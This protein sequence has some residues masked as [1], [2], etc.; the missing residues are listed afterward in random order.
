MP[1]LN[2]KSGRL[3]QSFNQ[4]VSM[5]QAMQQQAQKQSQTD[6][7]MQLQQ[8]QL[9]TFNRKE[10]ETS[11][12]DYVK[13]NSKNQ[14]W[15][16]FTSAM[17]TGSDKFNYNFI[18][19]TLASQGSIGPQDK[20]H[21]IEQEG[22]VKA[23]VIT[24]EGTS[25]KVVDIPM[26]A[27]LGK[28]YSKYNDEN[29]I[30]LAEKRAQ[31]IQEMIAQARL[32]KAQAV[33]SPKEFEATTLMG[34]MNNPESSEAEVTQATK[35]FNAISSDKTTQEAKKSEIRSEGLLFSTKNPYSS[36]SDLAPEDMKVRLESAA[37]IEG[38][39]DPKL[40]PKDKESL[41]NLST[42]IFE[43]RDILEDLT[44]KESGETKDLGRGIYDSTLRKAQQI[45]SDDSI[46]NMSKA[47]VSK[48]VDESKFEGAIGKF[49]SSYIKAI[50]GT[51]AAESEVQRL[52]DTLGISNWTNETTMRAKVQQFVETIESDYDRRLE[53][54]Y[55]KLPATA[56]L[57]RSKLS[58]NSSGKPKVET[59]KAP[60]V[61]SNTPISRVMN[62]WGGK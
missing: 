15:Q 42:T 5:V 48:L 12:Y 6:L 33:D 27:A 55:D 7:T 4:G 17:N 13:S 37:R 16:T 43:G 40:S 2:D 10:A 51:A 62:N 14:D 31:D 57:L 23:A 52:R 60:T 44:N 11:Q 47:E 46:K 21:F 39:L 9:E 32:T 19:Q 36:L 28:G 61:T 8:A 49:L 22:L 26:K 35:R 3:S 18:Q 50:S 58:K 24:P 41:T 59:P 54:L 38:A 30:I 53:T 45:L 29:R 25:D 56:M 20:L 1:F 34:I